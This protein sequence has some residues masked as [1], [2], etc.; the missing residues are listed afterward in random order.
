MVIVNNV[1]RKVPCPI[2][3]AC[4]RICLKWHTKSRRALFRVKHVRV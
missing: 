3:R 4:P 2:T 1:R